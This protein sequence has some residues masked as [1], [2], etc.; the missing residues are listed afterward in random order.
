MTTRL[1]HSN[2]I[3]LFPMR[4]I[5]LS[6]KNSLWVLG[7][8]ILSMIAE[9]L[10]A[11]DLKKLLPVPAE[12][13]EVLNRNCVL[14]HGA[15]IDG[16]KVQNGQL[17]ASD[18]L[19][20]SSDETIRETSARLEDFL[21]EVSEDNMPQAGKLKGELKER[22]DLT[23]ALAKIKK[24]YS[25]KDKNILLDWVSGK[26][27][28]PLPS[29]STQIKFISDEAVLDTILREASSGELPVSSRY[30]SL[31][32]LHNAG[33]TKERLQQTREAVTKL[34]LS[35][36][37]NPEMFHLVEIPVDG[38][39][40]LLLRFK[41]SDYFKPVI[42]ESPQDGKIIIKEWNAEHWKLLED[43]YPYGRDHFSYRSPSVKG[44]QGMSVRELCTSLGASHPFIR[45]D[46]VVFAAS[47]PPFY[48]H[49]LGLP[50][51]RL[52]LEKYLGLN[53]DEN[54]KAGNALR[55]GTGKSG[56]SKQNRLVEYH[57]LKRGSST[58]QYW[59][60]YDFATETDPKTQFRTKERN[61]FDFPLG[62]KSAG[63][64]S[65]FAFNHDGGEIIFTLPNG[66][67]AYLLVDKTGKRI[68]EAPTAIVADTG[69]SRDSVIRNGISCIAC[70][71]AG[72]KPI[73][74]TVVQ[75]HSKSNGAAKFSDQENQIF[76]KLYDGA[77]ISR[78][79]Q[80]EGDRY[81]NVL[82]TL[83]ITSEEEPIS[84]VVGRFDQKIYL[85]S[86][87]SELGLSE[88]RFAAL[89]EYA[90]LSN[91]LREIQKLFL[92]GLNRE[93]FIAQLPGLKL[94]PPFIKPKSGTNILPTPS[95]NPIKTPIHVRPYNEGKEIDPFKSSGKDSGFG[96]DA[97][98]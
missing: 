7:S 53:V 97:P 26:T 85:D 60:S 13:R 42:N 37:W 10:P 87:P 83:S 33:A 23:T 69:F 2:G 22:P 72:T 48:H 9:Q 25:E 91:D 4:T 58:A 30:L 74:D 40:G 12:V 1:S 57:E 94:S 59:L 15:S 81:R 82:T 75:Y 51:N 63:L 8:I 65:K 17:G 19:D 31:V 47:R 50:T 6:P 84:A 98:E 73:T 11:Q 21:T 70:H 90:D 46:W 27:P 95:D 55:S 64:S 44:G 36:S 20:L 41:L 16:K 38:V 43:A 67:H 35:L 89:E 32:N 39:D 86:G 45:A 14:C 29:P 49:L 34:M 79:L 68:D 3:R 78:L 93:E 62:P 77:T 54:L 61:L 24:N 76:E 52:A 18:G 66:L 56:V 80:E 71:N 88:K 92:K 28:N 96:T 5:C